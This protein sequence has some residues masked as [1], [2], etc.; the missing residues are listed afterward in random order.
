MLSFNTDYKL[1]FLDIVDFLIDNGNINHW[2]QISSPDFFKVLLS[3]V[4][5]GNEETIKLKILGLIKKWGLLFENK[6]NKIPNFSQIYKNLYQN[7]I[8]F[9][10]NFIS[11]Y[12]KY[13]SDTPLYDNNNYDNNN[14]IDNNDNNNNYNN[15][16]NNNNNNNNKEEYVFDYVESMKEIL[17]PSKFDTKYINLIKYLIFMIENISFGNELIDNQKKEDLNEVM[18]NLK[19]GNKKLIDVIEKGKVHNEYLMEICIGVND[20]TNR[21]LNRIDNFNTGKTIEHFLSYFIEKENF[22]NNNSKKKMKSNVN[23]FLII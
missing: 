13:L 1:I 20:D 21:T 16:N 18:N 4:K 12:Q 2:T 22:F 9:P 15:I 14:N 19:N 17:D 23:I 5:S 3:L 7:G 6:K 10:D 8:V 11:S